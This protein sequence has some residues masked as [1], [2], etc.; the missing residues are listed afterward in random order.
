MHT[1]KIWR[2]VVASTIGLLGDGLTLVAGASD[3]IGLPPLFTI[4]ILVVITSLTI[5][6]IVWDWTH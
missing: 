2:T 4:I 5:W 3:S 6:V 1:D